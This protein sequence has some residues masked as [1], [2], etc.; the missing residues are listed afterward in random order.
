MDFPCNECAK[1]FAKEVDLVIYQSRAHDKCHFSCEVCQENFIGKDKHRNHMRKHKKI[2]ICSSCPYETPYK[3]YLIKHVKTHDKEKVYGA[4]KFCPE[5]G[6]SFPAKRNLTKHLKIH[7]SLFSF[8]MSGYFVVV[9][10]LLVVPLGPFPLETLINF[11]LPLDPLPARSLSNYSLP[12][13]FVYNNLDQAFWFYSK[14]WINDKED[15]FY[16]SWIDR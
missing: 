2:N 9:G 6:K 1:S 3:W 16:C 5:C 8:N 7:Q 12:I 4:P 13:D 15:L 14:A 10:D 11:W